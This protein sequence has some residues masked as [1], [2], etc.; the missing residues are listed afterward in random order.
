MSKAHF[1]YIFNISCWQLNCSIVR[2]TNACDNLG[3]SYLF[4][5]VLMFI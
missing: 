1:K 3:E 5:F 4:N 2:K